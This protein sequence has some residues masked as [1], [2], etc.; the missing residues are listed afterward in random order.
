MEHD[1]LLFLGLLHLEKTQKHKSNAKS[2]N[3]HPFQSTQY[4]TTDI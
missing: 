1:F 3:V 2:C 4:V